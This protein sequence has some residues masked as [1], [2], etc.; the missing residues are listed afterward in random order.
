M[1]ILGSGSIH[2][3]SRYARVSPRQVTCGTDVDGTSH[4]KCF[5]LCGLFT[6]V[7]VRHQRHTVLLA[8]AG[9]RTRGIS[10]HHSL[11]EMP[12]GDVILL[13]C[14]SLHGTHLAGNTC[15]AQM[16]GAVTVKLC[17]HQCVTHPG[18]PLDLRVQECAGVP[19][20]AHADKAADRPQGVPLTVPHAPWQSNVH[21]CS[22]DMPE[23]AVTN[24]CCSR[25]LRRP[26]PSL[27][28]FVAHPV[29]GSSSSRAC[30]RCS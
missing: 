17:S 25:R 30:R 8:E 6:L 2:M 18:R 4:T 15:A 21:P 28:V 14:C 20:S 22:A 29:S 13:R 27:H 10:G 11:P 23:H 3:E 12:A 19:G 16:P 7:L 5:G 9:V 24:L 1:G 26:A